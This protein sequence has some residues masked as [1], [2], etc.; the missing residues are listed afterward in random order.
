RLFHIATLEKSVEG[1]R[2]TVFRRFPWE[3]RWHDRSHAFGDDNTDSGRPYGPLN[4]SPSKVA[5]RTGISQ[6][7]EGGNRD[8]WRGGPCSCACGQIVGN[9][10][11]VSHQS[12]ARRHP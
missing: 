8:S 4:G 1:T 12:G 9:D 11:T 6:L 2:R 5:G 10:S 3:L 7:S